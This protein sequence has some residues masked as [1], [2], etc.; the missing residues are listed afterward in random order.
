MMDCVSRINHCCLLQRASVL[1]H[2]DIAVNLG[3]SLFGRRGFRRG[4]SLPR[5]KMTQ[6]MAG[7]A[8]QEISIWRR[9][10]LHQCIRPLIGA[11]SGHHGYR[12]RRSLKRSLEAVGS[13]VI[14]RG[15]T[16]LHLFHLSQTSAVS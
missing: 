5:S 10:V 7:R 15:K 2:N 3:Q 11:S 4:Y 6:C 16:D 13:P 8:L 9:V 14:A 12:A 1:A